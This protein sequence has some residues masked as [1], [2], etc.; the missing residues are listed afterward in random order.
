[1]EP[2]ILAK[3]CDKIYRKYPEFTGKKPRVKAYSGTQNLL[4]FTSQGQAADGKPITRSLRVIA[5][6][7]GKIGKVTTSR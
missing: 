7:N 3:I 5:D 1:M 6:E 2:G 4:I